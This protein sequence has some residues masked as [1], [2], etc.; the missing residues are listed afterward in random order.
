[1]KDRSRLISITTTCAMLVVMACVGLYY[2]QYDYDATSYIKAFGYL[3][4]TASSVLALIFLG[5]EEG[6]R[7]LA[8]ASLAFSAIMLASS[9]FAIIPQVG[10]YSVLLTYL[11]MAFFAPFALCFIAKIATGKELFEKVIVK[12]L[13]LVLSIAIVVVYAIIPAGWSQIALFV[14]AGIWA[15]IL[16]TGSVFAI[17]NLI[18]K[19]EEFINWTYLFFTLPYAAT[20][21]QFIINTRKY[22]KT[23][24]GVAMMA[25]AFLIVALVNKS[26]NKG[27]K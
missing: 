22:V 4:L 24:A 14:V 15:L 12:A 21:V 20:Y 3:A 8:F 27:D 26:E 13:I 1:M 19:K 17:V 6:K 7:D 11:A 16:L 5:K 10:N 25:L 9:V 2:M 18:K 23:C